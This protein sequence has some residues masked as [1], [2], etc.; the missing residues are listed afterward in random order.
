MI[1][2]EKKQL[3]FNFGPLDP[4]HIHNHYNSLNLTST[5]NKSI[6]VNFNNFV[7]ASAVGRAKCLLSKRLWFFEKL[8][9][10]SRSN[11]YIKRYSCSQEEH[12]F[13]VDSIA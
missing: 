3:Y 2:Y 11:C 8:N 9:F 6:L 13:E 10:L 12:Y 5:Q 4:C 1:A 7:I